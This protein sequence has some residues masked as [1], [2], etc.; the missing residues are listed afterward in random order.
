MDWIRIGGFRV[1][2]G[3]R[4]GW[5]INKLF[6]CASVNKNPNLFTMKSTLLITSLLASTT[7]AFTSSPV[8]FRRMST[9]LNSVPLANGK[10]S[11]DRVCR[12]W[13][14][15][16]EGDKSTSESLSQISDVVDE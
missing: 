16:Y 5:R 6:W 12:E 10:M 1:D 8:A 11:F 3:F 13:R 4:D 14:C 7:S 15:K 2:W 9:G